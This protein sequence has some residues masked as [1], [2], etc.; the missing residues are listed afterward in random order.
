M[1]LQAAAL[2]TL[3]S[4]AVCA[5]LLAYF[6]FKVLPLKIELRSLIGYL[7]ACGAAW[8]VASRLELGAP[9]WNLLGRSSTALAV[10]AGALYLLD[11]RVRR[12]AA[13]L[14]TRFSQKATTEI[15]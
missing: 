14:W 4:F 5:L 13:Q 11:R 8:L 1:G 6:S 3:I 12:V 7:V 2:A 9:F 10:Y 15:V